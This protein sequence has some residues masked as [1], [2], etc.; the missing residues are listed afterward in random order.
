[1]S[2]G[3]RVGFN[4]SSSLRGARRNLPSVE[5]NPAAVRDYLEEELR[6]ATVRPALPEESVHIS[7][8]GLIPKGGPKGGQT[9][10]FR[11]IVDLS[12]SLVASVN[13]GIDPELCSQSYSSVDEAVARVCQCGPGAWMAKLDLKSAYRKVPVHP[14]DQ[15][16]LGMAWGGRTFCDRAFPFG[17]RSAPK[18]F[19]AVADGLSWALQREGIANVLHY[20]D[21]FFFWSEG[22]SPNCANA[23]SLA[24]PLCRRLGLP[25]AP[26]KVVGP[27]I[28]LVFLGILF[29]SVH[30]E[31]RLPEEKLAW[32]RTEIRAWGGV[33]GSLPPRGNCNR[34]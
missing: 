3:F 29:D 6:Q 15:P 21:D 25:M 4:R 19:T 33:V 12:S 1:M 13:D 10:R 20:L 30:Q 27:S 32:L 24:V 28:S 14:D 26:Q 7:P 18:L 34:S 9:G 8:I 31:I 11:L 5:A 2:Q 17:L 23:L 16:L 22:D